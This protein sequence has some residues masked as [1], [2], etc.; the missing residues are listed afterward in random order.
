MVDSVSLEFLNI[1]IYTSAVLAFKKTECFFVSNS[2]PHE[3]NRRFERVNSSAEGVCWFN[4]FKSFFIGNERML[5]R[6]YFESVPESDTDV[7]IIARIFTNGNLRLQSNIHYSIKEEDDLFMDNFTDFITLSR[8]KFAIE[9][10][11]R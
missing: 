11:F 9:G 7:F 3:L 4:K 10:S 5:T 1:H 8:S 6:E 2:K